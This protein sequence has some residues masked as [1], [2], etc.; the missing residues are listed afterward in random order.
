MHI[1]YIK[2]YN[3]S[4]LSAIKHNGLSAYGTSA[5]WLHASSKNT[6]TQKENIQKNPRYEFKEITK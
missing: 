2:N 4:C 5:S 6:D 3:K 1:Q